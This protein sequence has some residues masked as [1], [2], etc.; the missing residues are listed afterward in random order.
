MDTLQSAI[1]R[2]TPAI[3]IRSGPFPPGENSG[4]LRLSEPRARLGGARTNLS[5][6]V[7]VSFRVLPTEAGG[8]RWEIQ[9]TAYSYLLFLDD[10]EMI[11]NHWDPF[12]LGGGG[13]RFPHVHLGKDLR[14]AGM[15]QREREKLGLLSAAHVKPDSS[16]SQS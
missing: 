11:A 1:A 7:A 14:H 9:T 5:L 3:L 12:P 2:A 16:R 4:H 10:S 6:T 8:G 13:V 15:P